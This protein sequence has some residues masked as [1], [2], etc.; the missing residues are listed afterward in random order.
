MPRLGDAAYRLVHV[1]RSQVEARTFFMLIAPARRKARDFRFEIPTSFEGPLWRLMRQRPANLLAAQ[2]ADWDAFLLEAL[3]AAERLPAACRDLASCTWGK[4]NAVR[5][6]HPLSAAA[7]AVI[8]VARHAERSWWPEDAPTC[9]EFKDPTT[10]HPNASALLP[11]TRM[12]VIFTCRA[13]KAAIRSRPSFAPASQP[14]RQGKPTPFLPGPV[15][16][17]LTLEP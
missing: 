9:R 12:R 16:H 17:S 8:R 15:A 6:A 5:I 7:A 1:F 11:D 3:A 2:Y 14:G 4:V 10:V 13:D